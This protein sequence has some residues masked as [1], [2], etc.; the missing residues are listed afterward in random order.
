MEKKTSYLTIFKFSGA[1]IA[2][3]IGSG[4]ASGQEI[5]QFFSSYGLYGIYG[6]LTSMLLFAVCSAI[7]MTFGFR[8][9]EKEENE[10]NIFKYYAGKIVGTFLEWYTPLFCFAVSVVMI[11]GAGATFQQYFGF[12][13]LTGTAIMSISVLIVTVF[14]MKRIADIIG[15]LGPITI[16]FTISVGLYS[17][18]T[19]PDSISYLTAEMG[20][21]TIQR[22]IGDSNDFWFLSA[23]SYVSFNLILGIP[24]IKELGE[25]AKVK[26]EAFLGGILG[27]V[28]FMAAGLVINA[29]LLGHFS[30]VILLEIPILYLAE[31][32]SPV[33]GLIFSFILLGEIFSTAAPMVWTAA[34]ALADEK[35]QPGKYK[36]LVVL[37]S[38]FSFFGG[39]LSFAALVN[40]VYPF[41]GL[42][43]IVFIVAL[44]GKEVYSHF[45]KVQISE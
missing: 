41:T 6:I 15:F 23:V 28:G 40:T 21:T 22:S 44:I 3:L 25:T 16:V 33:I 20:A 27:A 7:I 24:F 39:Q 19:N 14:G 34:S 29:A 2:V 31:G 18:F 5:I 26:R 11:S 32:I 38:I 10:K 4:F 13:S 9:R 17:I 42:L 12:R 45:K 37:I 8:T 36:L 43:G 35:E 30:E 1:I